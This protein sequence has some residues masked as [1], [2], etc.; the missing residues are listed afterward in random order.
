MM[1]TQLGG[2]E[3]AAAAVSSQQRS[4]YLQTH[5][6]TCSH[7]IAADAALTCFAHSMILQ[8]H[9]MLRSVLPVCQHL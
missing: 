1:N 9:V 6:D 7:T 4:C 2:V 5:K 8:L 3:S